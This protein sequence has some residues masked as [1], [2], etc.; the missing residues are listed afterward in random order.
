MRWYEEGEGKLRD[1]VNIEGRLDLRDY[2]RTS[3]GNPRT[4]L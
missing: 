4:A 3:S 1:L 2:L